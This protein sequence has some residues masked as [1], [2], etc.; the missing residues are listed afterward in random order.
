MTE[1][2]ENLAN[3]LMRFSGKLIIAVLIIVIGFK[4]SKF[5]LNHI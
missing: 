3:E 2:L 1:V 4:F 5:L